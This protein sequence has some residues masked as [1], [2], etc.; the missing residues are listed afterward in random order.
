VRPEKGDSKEVENYKLNCQRS[1]MMPGGSERYEVWN[2]IPVV[3]KELSLC[4]SIYASSNVVN[5]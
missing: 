1:G 4:Y 3:S 2:I 5:K